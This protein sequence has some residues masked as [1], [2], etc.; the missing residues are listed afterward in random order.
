MGRSFASVAQTHLNQLRDRRRSVEKLCDLAMHLAPADRAL[1]LQV[2]GKGQSLA[3]LAKLRDEPSRSTQ[4]RMRSLLHRMSLPEYRLLASAGSTLPAEIR[5]CAALVICK[6]HTMR[7][8]AALSGRSLHHV[9]E[10]VQTVRTLA[11]L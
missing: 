1:V 8:A 6:G 3:D 10:Y 9:R 4:R 11:R 7:D 2:L 5:Q